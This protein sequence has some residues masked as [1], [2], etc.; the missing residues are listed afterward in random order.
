MDITMWVVPVVMRQ[1]FIWYVSGLDV[2]WSVSF[3]KG[4]LCFPES[5]QVNGTLK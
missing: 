2:S 5:D 4:F 3:L 1:I